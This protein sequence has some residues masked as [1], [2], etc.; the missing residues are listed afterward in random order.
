MSSL[1]ERTAT[2]ILE[3]AATVFAEHGA[4]A[5]MSDVAEEAGVGRATIY[6]HYPNRETL[7]Q[8]LARAALAEAADRLA[9]AD[10]D[11]APVAEAIARVVRA[12]AAIGDRYVVL[13]QEQVPYDPGEIEERLTAPVQAVIVRGQREGVL[14]DDLP[15]MWLGEVLGGLISGGLRLA[16]RERLGVERTSEV[17]TSA[18][19][20][21]ARP[22]A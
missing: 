8:A 22:R 14:R 2:V 16:Q 4:A 9:E 3:A 19:L 11:H 7:L 18:F 6:R 1:S 20:D 10:L 15:A 12:F 21:G 13:V 5:S 17:V